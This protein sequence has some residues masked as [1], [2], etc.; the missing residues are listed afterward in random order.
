MDSIRTVIWISAL[1]GLA[2]FIAVLVYAPIPEDGHGRRGVT[3]ETGGAAMS[4]QEQGNRIRRSLAD[5]RH[6]AAISIANQTV[7]LFPDDPEAWLWQVQVQYALGQ[8]TGA[9]VA[10]ERL[11]NAVQARPLPGGQLPQAMR[12]YQLGWANWAL[13]RQEIARQHFIDAAN[14]F[15]PASDGLIEERARQYTLASFLAMGGQPER[16]AEHF[17]LAVDANYRGTS[18]W[19]KVDPALASIRGQRA[20]LDAGVVLQRRAEERERQRQEHLNPPPP[21]PPLPTPLTPSPSD[22]PDA[23]G[24]EP[25]P[26]PRGAPSQMPDEE[27]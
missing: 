18:G 7:E 23:R 14:L 3:G 22:S 4:L 17:A 26:M 15:A 13:S 12:A 20:Y 19:W 21:H 2:A 25:I 9:R 8:E 16:A 10:A 1:L 5:N 24:A 6:A 11:L 27:S